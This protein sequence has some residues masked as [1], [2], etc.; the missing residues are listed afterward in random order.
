MRLG[1][2]HQ[3]DPR[4]IGDEKREEKIVLRWLAHTKL[5]EKRSSNRMSIMLLDH[6][7]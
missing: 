7:L 2:S 4:R 3:R 1:S 6:G 5:K